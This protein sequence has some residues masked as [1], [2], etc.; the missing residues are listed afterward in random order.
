MRTVPMFSQGSGDDPMR[1][2]S[3]VRCA[4]AL[5][6]ALLLAFASPCLASDVAGADRA[7]VQAIAAG[8]APLE[9]KTLAGKSVSLQDLHGEVVVLN[10]WATWCKPCIT[11][12]PVLAKLA[13]RFG[14]RGL[15]VI[16][17]SVDETAS[18]AEL[19]QFAEKL[20]RAME[21][22]VGATMSD[23]Q[24]MRVQALPTTIIIDRKGTLIR[25]HHGAVS[26]GFL[27]ES[28]EELLGRGGPA[29]RKRTFSE[30]SEA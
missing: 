27:D 26:E 18:R 29:P 13:Q 23:I 7:G 16:A 14:S 2:D 10:F 15:R 28:L 21:V 9:M 6:V 3:P 12:M 1:N 4:A 22:W 20:P 30:G 11:E 24:R 17:A 5:S 8:D 25:V 19:E